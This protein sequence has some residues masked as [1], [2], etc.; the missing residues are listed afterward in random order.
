M[1]VIDAEADGQQ[2][3][4]ESLTLLKQNEMVLV[5]HKG[6]NAWLVCAPTRIAC[7]QMELAK[8]RPKGSRNFCFVI[9]DI[10]KFYNLFDEGSLPST[11]DSAEKL[12]IFEQA[13][14]RVAL[15]NDTNVNDILLRD[16]MVQGALFPEAESSIRSYFKELEIGLEGYN[17]QDLLLGKDYHAALATSANFHGKGNI[18]DFEEAKDF[19]EGLGVKLCVTF[20]PVQYI[21]PGHW[22]IYI[23]QDY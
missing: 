9:G 22:T 15:A 13:H 18:V 7:E 17:D 6:L 1:R 11:L 10:E 8:K 23:T 4:K 5:C 21:D 16:G 14:L 19:A 20:N 12:A 2:A 3:L